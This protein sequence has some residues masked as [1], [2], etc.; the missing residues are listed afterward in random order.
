LCEQLI[1]EETFMNIR[2]LDHVSFLVRDVERSRRFYSQ[3]LGLQEIPRPSNASHPGAWLTNDKHSFEVHL[4]GEA[5]E[6]RVVQTHMPY[7]RDEMATGYG[8]HA[9]FEVEDLK[10]AVQHLRTLNVE[11]VGGPRPRGDGVQQIF[12]CDPDGHMIELFV[13]GT[14]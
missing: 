14:R 1:E 2:K 3:V 9:A 6:G 7:R 8:S 11:L 12:I 13:R 4:I 5:E 10:A